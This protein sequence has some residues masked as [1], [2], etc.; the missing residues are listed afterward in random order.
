MAFNSYEGTASHTSSSMLAGARANDPEA[1]RRI[2]DRYSR[3]IYRWCRKAGLQPEDASDVVQEVFRAVARK[4]V[5]FHHDQQGDTFR[6]WLYRITQNKLRDYFAR[7]PGHRETALGGTDAQRQFMELAEASS[8][9]EVTAERQPVYDR[10]H[11][12][13]LQRVQAEFS[14]RDWRVFWRVVV[15]GQTSTEAGEQFQM[16]SNAVRLVKMRIMRRVREMLNECTDRG[17][18]GC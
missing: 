17:I 4:L 7:T 5:D 18:D 15:D 10:L 9:T 14:E 12:A 6:G 1:W 8:G 3:R 16:S 13:I 11:G 2:V